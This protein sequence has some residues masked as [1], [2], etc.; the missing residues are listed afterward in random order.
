LEPAI[1][2][3]SQKGLAFLFCSSARYPTLTS[4][5]AERVQHDS[6][7]AKMGVTR[8][9]DCYL[10]IADLLLY[11]ASRIVRALLSSSSRSVFDSSG[12]MILLTPSRPS[13]LG[14]ESVVPKS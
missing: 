12:M 1:K 13:T 8:F 5:R 4:D 7:L 3:S 6:L 11:A 9:C 2:A 10:P 14:R